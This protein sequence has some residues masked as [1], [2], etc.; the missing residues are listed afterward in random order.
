MSMSP[1]NY[2]GIEKKY[3]EIKDRIN[4]ITDDRNPL[5][6]PYN[7][8]N[9]LQEVSALEEWIGRALRNLLPDSLEKE[10]YQEMLTGIKELRDNLCYLVKRDLDNRLK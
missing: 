1:D 7:N 3:N 2:V 8:I 6:F 4:Y 9:E 5:S 10:K